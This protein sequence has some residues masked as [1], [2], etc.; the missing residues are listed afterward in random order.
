[1]L[2]VFVQSLIFELSVFLFCRYLYTL[3]KM[4]HVL[5]KSLEGY[6][7]QK[8]NMIVR[9]KVAV[10]TRKAPAKKGD[11][12]GGSRFITEFLSAPC[13]QVVHGKTD[14][15]FMTFI[16]FFISLHAQ[17]QQKLINHRS[18]VPMKQRDP[19]PQIL[20][21]LARRLRLRMGLRLNHRRKTIAGGKIRTTKMRKTLNTLCKNVGL[22]LSNLR[23][24]VVWLLCLSFEFDSPSGHI[25]YY[26]FYSFL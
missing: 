1:M 3:L 16:Y 24:W 6:S 14:M 20:N 21:R 25:S 2:K 19:R 10:R 23:G 4:I 22:C 15:S 26:S 9:K 5:L 8:K 7:K 18:R 17:P 11:A 13:W 12:G